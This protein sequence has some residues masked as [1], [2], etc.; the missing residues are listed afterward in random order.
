MPK[1]DKQLG[2]PKLGQSKLSQERILQCSHTLL[3]Q[4]GKVP[5]IRKIARNLDVD[6][7]AIYYYFPN[8]SSLL[9]TLALS[10]MK[11]IHTPRPGALWEDELK[12]LCRSYLKLLHS[13]SGLL[14]IFLT[15]KTDGPAQV[16]INRFESIVSP[17]EIKET[18]LKNGL[19]LLADYLHG[20]AL[21]MH[22]AEERHTMSLEMLDGPLEFYIRALSISTKH[23]L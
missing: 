12:T 5:S 19:Y 20:F 16:F 17:L 22:C 1:K 21:A 8:K 4:S 2:R 3:K 23:R 10:L 13:Y 11:S 7:M 6:P 9:E 15:M 14:E 18:D